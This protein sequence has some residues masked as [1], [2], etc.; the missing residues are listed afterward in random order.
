M[1]QVDASRTTIPERI[2]TGQRAPLAG[3]ASSL[4][5]GPPWNT[6]STTFNSATLPKWPQQ[7]RATEHVAS[8]PRAPDG[9]KT[10]FHLTLLLV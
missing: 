2:E 10:I 5:P 1:T 4:R 7:L 3:G 8:H 9:G 6:K